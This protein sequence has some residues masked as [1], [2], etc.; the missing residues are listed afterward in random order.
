MDDVPAIPVL[1]E[2][3]VC[4][5]LSAGRAHNVPLEHAV[6]FVP[7]DLRDP[8]R[9][10]LSQKFSELHL[11]FHS[12]RFDP[13]VDVAQ[14]NLYTFPWDC[15]GKEKRVLS[16]FFEAAQMGC[17]GEINTRFDSRWDREHA[18]PPM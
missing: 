10:Q 15:R 13:K 1:I 9:R 11:V 17:P 2:V 7:P 3:V 8:R 14:V 18:L 4:N 12:A 5:S 6:L 16:M